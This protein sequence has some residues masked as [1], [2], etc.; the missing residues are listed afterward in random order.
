[1][2]DGEKIF[3]ADRA[4]IPQPVLKTGSL[5]KCCHQISRAMQ[6]KDVENM[7]NGRMLQRGQG[8]AFLDEALPRPF[9]VCRVVFGSG[10]DGRSIR[11]PNSEIKGQ[12]FLDR[13]LAVEVGVIRKIG[14]TKSAVTQQPHNMIL[15]QAESRRQRVLVFGR[16]ELVFGMA[17]SRRAAIE[18]T[19]DCHAAA[20]G[21]DPMRVESGFV[22]M[23]YP[24][25]LPLC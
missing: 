7:E 24:C 13:D 12:Q 2:W 10:H 11:F 4:A 19:E 5:D 8:A 14:Q 25:E 9:E 15:A 20:G 1:M 18:L 17:R 3:L 23:F 22:S 16:H 6:F 21:W